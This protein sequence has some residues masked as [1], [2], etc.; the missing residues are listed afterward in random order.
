MRRNHDSLE[1]VA[2]GYDQPAVFM[3][4]NRSAY[5]T[6]NRLDHSDAVNITHHLLK[7]YEVFD[8]SMLQLPQQ[9]SFE[10]FLHTYSWDNIF[11]TRFTAVRKKNALWIDWDCVHCETWHPYDGFDGYGPEYPRGF[12][13]EKDPDPLADAPLPH[14]PSSTMRSLRAPLASLRHR[15]HQTFT[16]VSKASR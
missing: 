1:L 12:D 11:P 15:L 7:V 16:N 5:R 13:P 8:A 2:Q 10:P 9:G 6:D 3:T 14:R 4:P